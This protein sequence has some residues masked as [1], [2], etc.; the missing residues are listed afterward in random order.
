MLKKN[1]NYSN[2]TTYVSSLQVEV[3]IEINNRKES[4]IQNKQKTE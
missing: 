2:H 3:G 1:I 4:G